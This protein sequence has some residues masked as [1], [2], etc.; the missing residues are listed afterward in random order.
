[1][2]SQSLKNRKDCAHGQYYKPKVKIIYLQ[3]LD[4]SIWYPLKGN[5]PQL[6]GGFHMRPKALIPT[7]HAFICMF[8]GVRML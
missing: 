4:H 7:A 5:E 2:K 6:V 3:G 8:L 1:M